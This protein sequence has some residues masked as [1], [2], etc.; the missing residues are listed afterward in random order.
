MVGHAMKVPEKLQLTVY[1]TWTLS[2]PSSAIQFDSV[3][4]EDSGGTNVLCPKHGRSAL[5]S[6][7]HRHLTSATE[8]SESLRW[9]RWVVVLGYALEIVTTNFLGLE[10]R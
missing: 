10:Y 5:S 9:R 2:I 7:E 6:V 4:Q 3:R 1:L 8:G